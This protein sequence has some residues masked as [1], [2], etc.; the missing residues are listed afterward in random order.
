MQEL[1]KISGEILQRGKPKTPPA[2]SAD[3]GNEG[4]GQ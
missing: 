4:S 3:E 2:D 1:D